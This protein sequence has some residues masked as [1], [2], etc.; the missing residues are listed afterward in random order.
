MPQ[1]RAMLAELAALSIIISLLSVGVHRYLWRR[2]WQRQGAIYTIQKGDSLQSIAL[3]YTLSWKH[4]ARLNRLKAP[5]V[6]VRGRRIR[7]PLQ[8]NPTKPD[9]KA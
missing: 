6:V 4:I 2:K 3:R 5:Y 9:K 8:K 1:P 7:L